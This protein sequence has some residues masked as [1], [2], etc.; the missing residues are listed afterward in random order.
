MAEISITAAYA[1]VVEDDETGMLFIGFAEGE[2]EDEPYVMFR[3]SLAGGPIWFEAGS[4]EF[5]DEDAIEEV[6]RTPSGLTL[7]VH[8]DKAIAL[9]FVHE[10]EVKIG[11]DCEDADLGIAALK[12]ML[13][14][15][16]R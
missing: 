7:V 2:D 13:G 1:S 5:G 11:P 14:A 6:R 10:I 12:E 15:K 9:G 4:E 16:F 3:Q 8:P